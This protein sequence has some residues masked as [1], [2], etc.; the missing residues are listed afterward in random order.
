MIAIPARLRRLLGLLL[1]IAGAGYLLVNLID[2]VRL[3]TATPPIHSDFH[4]IWSYARIAI[5][6]GGAAVYDAAHLWQ[7]E[8]ALGRDPARPAPLPFAYPP[9]FLLLIAPLAWL[10]YA[11]AYLAWVLV[12][13][14]IFVI[15]V[16]GLRGR[17]LI[18]LLAPATTAAIIFG[19]T[20]LLAA[21]LLVG[22]LRAVPT[23]PVL[24]GV[25]FGLA[26]CKPQLGLLIPVALLARGQWQAILA[27][28][29]TVLVLI[30]ATSALWG[31]AIWTSWLGVLPGYS[32]RF[33]A[34]MGPYWYLVPTVEGTL[35]QLGAPSSLAR[36]AQLLVALPVVVA[37]WLLFRRAAY[38]VACAGLLVGTF[39]V[40]PHAF[41]YDLPLAAAG[42]YIY[43]TNAVI[44]NWCAAA[45]L[46]ALAAPALAMAVPSAAFLMLLA[47]ASLFVIVLLGA[48]V[49]KSAIPRHR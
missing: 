28:G 41:V 36:V 46:A 8:L 42:V 5:A 14:A 7:S 2:T 33:D 48:P 3:A 40:T 29:L 49:P 32:Q 4:A 17:G 20:G 9:P 38:P 22:G 35:H 30:L 39:L 12:T 44:S 18:L 31:V 47:N 37:I 19:Q 34:E 43:A 13:A 11:P 24:A 26:A 25:L 10:D 21:G 6:D 15:G 27:A 23:R 45:L 16:A 1:A